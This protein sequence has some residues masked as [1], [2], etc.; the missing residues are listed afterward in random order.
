MLS[1][2]CWCWHKSRDVVIIHLSLENNLYF[3]NLGNW[4]YGSCKVSGRARLVESNRRAFKEHQIAS[5]HCLC[6]ILYRSLALKLS[7]SRINF[8]SPPIFVFTIYFRHYFENNKNKVSVFGEFVNSKHTEWL[9]RVWT[10]Y[11]IYFWSF[12]VF[13]EL[14][15]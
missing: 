4:F 10:Q 7:G 14:T 6:I 12:D 8:L 2:N 1:N 13:C 11:L 15:K 5:V 9:Y 3:L